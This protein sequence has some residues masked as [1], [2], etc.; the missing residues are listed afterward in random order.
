MPLPAALLERLKKR[1]IVNEKLSTTEPSEEKY[2]S[3]TDDS[4]SHSDNSSK[5]ISDEEE[6]IAE[7][8]DDTEGIGV[9]D[10]DKFEYHSKPKENLWK[11]RLKSRIA[12]ENDYLGHKGCPNKYNV[13]HRC[14]LFCLEYWKDGQIE[15][16][17]EYMVRYKRLIDRYPLPKG[18]TPIYDPGLAAFY[19]W[20]E[21]EQNV[22]WLPPSHPKAKISKSAAVLRREM[23]FDHVQ[24]TQEDGVGPR[25]YITKPK[26]VNEYDE[27]LKPPVVKPPKPKPTP[28][29]PKWNRKSR[30]D[31]APNDP[32]DPS[33]YSDSCPKGKWSS[34]LE[35]TEKKGVDTTV[36]GAGFQQR[37]YPSPGAVL[38]ANR[39]GRG[40]SRSRSRS[41]S[42]ERDD[43]RRDDRSRRNRR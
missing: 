29:L 1:G 31:L 21:E 28:K 32:M 27:K 2:H 37:P 40:R 25:I 17:D 4:G 5:H 7:D 23:D 18:W 39:G 22:S 30:A 13:F 35:G 41:N 26:P 11:L 19:F 16:D 14:T 9:Q 43:R 3:D 6:I 24:N 33:S 38:A 42:R 20:N 34:G 12:V 8:Y 15:P 36:S 10:P